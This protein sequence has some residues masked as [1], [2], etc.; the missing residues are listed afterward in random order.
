[1]SL[2]IA[3][4]YDENCNSSKF[5]TVDTDFEGKRAFELYL[6]SYQLILR[7]Q[8]WW[9]MK[10]RGLPAELEVGVFELSH[11]VRFDSRRGF[12]SGSQKR[13]LTTTWLPAALLRQRFYPF[14]DR[15]P[16]SGPRPLGPPPP[17]AQLQNPNRHH[18][19]HRLPTTLQLAIRRDLHRSRHR[20]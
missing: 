18:L 7:K 4:G 16:D 9:L 19:R 14:T 11:T 3:P 13:C 1:M 5:L 2:E 20:H 10:E 12:P 8:L 17:K 15:P 6:V